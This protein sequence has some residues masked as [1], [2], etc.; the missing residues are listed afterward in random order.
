MEVPEQLERA[1]HVLPSRLAIAL[2]T[3]LRGHLP[4]G[5]KPP[6]VADTVQGR[7]LPGGVVTVGTIGSE[8]AQALEK[9][10][11]RRAKRAR[12]LRF[13]IDGRI[14]FRRR[15]LLRRDRPGGKPF[16]RALRRRGLIVE[17]TWREVMG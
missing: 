14:L 17:R 13:E 15:S 1:R 6:H 12:V 3:D 4:R 9:G 10:A 2:S 7:V 16:T 11:M 5:D 8:Y